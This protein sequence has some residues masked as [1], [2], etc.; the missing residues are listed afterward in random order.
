MSLF[1]MIYF[2]VGFFFVLLENRLNLVDYE[3]LTR[4]QSIYAVLRQSVHFSRFWLTYPWYV[5]E[6]FLIILEHRTDPEE[7]E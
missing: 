4:R 7:E 5:A 2:G 1:W 6:D 3:G